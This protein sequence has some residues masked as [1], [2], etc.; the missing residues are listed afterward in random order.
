MSNWNFRPKLNTDGHT[1]IEQE[2]L[3]INNFEDQ[4]LYRLYNAADVFM[5]ECSHDGLIL[6]SAYWFSP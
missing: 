4:I 2:A 1:A 3:H 5:L 6:N